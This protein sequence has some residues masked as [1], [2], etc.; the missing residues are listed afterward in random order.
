MAAAILR[1]NPP[2]EGADADFNGTPLVGHPWFRAWRYCRT[3]DYGATVAT[4][5]RAGA[6]RP[7]AIEGT[8]AVQDLLRGSSSAS[9]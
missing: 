9:S 4:L 3:G 2:L 1:Y 8:A 6:K 5:L 7:D